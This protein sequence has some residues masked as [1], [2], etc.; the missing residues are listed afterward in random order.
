MEGGVQVNNPGELVK[1]HKFIGTQIFADK[2]G[3][4]KDA[5]RIALSNC[6]CTSVSKKEFPIQSRQMA[7]QKAPDAR[8]A[9]PEA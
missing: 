3:N 7:K 6:L 1:S 2:R 8:R 5:M 4:K 9:N